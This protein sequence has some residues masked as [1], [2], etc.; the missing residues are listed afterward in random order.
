MYPGR[1]LKTPPTQ[2]SKGLRKYREVLRGDRPA[3]EEEGAMR[4]T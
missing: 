2:K 3:A 4:R 1:P